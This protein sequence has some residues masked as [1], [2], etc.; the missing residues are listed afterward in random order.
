MD[1]LGSSTV[2][3]EDRAATPHALLMLPLAE[4]KVCTGDCQCTPKKE[5]KKPSAERPAVD[6][7]ADDPHCS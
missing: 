4:T 7:E 3:L 1:R 2:V 5:S 6:F